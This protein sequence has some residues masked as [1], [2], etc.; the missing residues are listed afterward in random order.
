MQFTAHAPDANSISSKTGKGTSCTRVTITRVHLPYL[1]Y[2]SKISM[3]DADA[4][5]P[6]R[7]AIPCCLAASHLPKFISAPGEGSRYCTVPTIQDIETEF[8]VQLGLNKCLSGMIP[9]AT[10]LA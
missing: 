3:A 10:A 7:E 4:T 9:H 1:M 6:A 2:A 5:H 8:D